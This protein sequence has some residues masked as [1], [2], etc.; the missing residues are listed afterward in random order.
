M[1]ESKLDGNYFGIGIEHGKNKL[2]Y[3]T[4]YRTASILGAKFLFIIGRRFK[5]QCSDTVKSWRSVPMFS[6]ET[7]DDF[8]KNLPHDCQLIG[9]EMINKACLVEN[10]THPK[11]ACY[12][13]GA[14]DHGL[15]SEA[16]ARCHKFIK[17]RGLY[18]LNVSVAGSIVIYD[19][20]TKISPEEYG[21]HNE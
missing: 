5:Q 9:V 14:E 1:S 11:R 21:T 17:L 8:Y 10:F 3:G 18:S 16:L 15:T 13:L 7:F 12:L 20:L 2:N 19:R 4:L 6:Y